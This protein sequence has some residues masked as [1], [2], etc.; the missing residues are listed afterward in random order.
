MRA[1]RVLVGGAL[2]V[3]V[4]LLAWRSGGPRLTGERS[5]GG[6]SATSPAGALAP[7]RRDPHRLARASIAGRITT[8]TADGGAPIGNAN[9]CAVADDSRLTGEES[10]DPICGRSAED[11]TY[12]LVDLVPASHRIYASAR[13]HRPAEYLDGDRPAN[14]DLGPGENRR[15]VD[16]VLATGGER[17]SGLV[18]DI[19]GG[20]VA[21]A[22]VY[23]WRV[24][25]RRA[26]GPRATTLSDAEG[27]FELWLPPG[28]AELIA[29]AEGYASG[30]R[31]TSAPGPS[32][33]ILL[34]PEATLIGRVVEI[35]SHRPVADAIVHARAENG[36]DSGSARS[37]A[38]GR[39]RLT[40]LSPGRYR[41]DAT[42]NTGFGASA[43]SVR[44]GLGQVSAE[45]RVELHPAVL[46]TGRV[47]R[48]DARPCARGQVELYD[49]LQD[50]WR[51]ADVEPDGEVRLQ[52]LLPGRYEVTVWCEDSVPADRYPEVDVAA[53]PIHGLRWR[54]GAGHVVRGVVVATDGAPLADIVV[55]AESVRG[56][57]GGDRRWP[58]A[59][60]DAAG[61]FRIPGVRPGRH[62]LQPWS[63]DHT[64]P[65]DPVE[66]TVD[67]SRD[68]DGVRIVMGRGETIEGTVVEAGGKPLGGVRVTA[69]VQG[70]T[71]EDPCTGDDGAFV[72]HGLVPGRYRVVAFDEWTP[73]RSPGRDDDEP[74]G[75]EVAVARGQRARVRLVV[76]R[77][78]GHI[79]GRVLDAAGKPVTD[80]LI[81]AERESEATGMSA[82][83]A[84]QAVRW[85]WW[86]QPALTDTNGRFT[87]DRLAPGRYT[88]HAARKGGG[89]VLAEHV[90]AGD[91]IT[92]KIVENGRIE[93][94]AVGPDGAAPQQFSITLADRATSFERREQYFRTAGRFRLDDLPAGRFELTIDSA[95]ASGTEQVTLGQGEVKPDVR[96]MLAGLGTVRGRVVALDDGAPVPG[97]SMLARQPGAM[98]EP[99]SDGDRQYVSDADGRFEL[100]RVPAG[101]V[102][103][104]GLPIDADTRSQFSILFG[105]PVTVRPGE[106]VVLPELRVARLRL[107]DN[108]SAGGDLGFRLEQR[109]VGADD[110]WDPTLKV[111]FVRPD[112]PAARAGLRVGDQIVAIDG[113]DVRGDD[114]YLYPMLVRVPEGTR[115]ALD[116]A[117][118]AT[119]SIIAGAPSDG[120]PGLPSGW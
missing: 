9:V 13:G 30:T 69:Y 12:A 65:S 104:M 24:D 16:V 44:L 114:A 17:V 93:G 94:V 33:V 71:L 99:R 5:S 100:D 60:T 98:P 82:G 102:F 48:D 18:K 120:S 23:G 10:R 64:G 7:P 88:V 35:G 115:I 8:T 28:S 97:M 29:E 40:R 57:P 74:Q 108:Y 27:R 59:K 110:P 14:V 107:A 117:R 6:A 118:G 113:H 75:V 61:R 38:E 46:V 25:N 111:A 45:V 56:D 34:T 51:G 109:E 90:R 47:D 66:V 83:G 37:D 42:T 20:P 4:A 116:V 73:L 89:E 112:G 67:E 50:V 43:D 84:R 15:G 21:G 103:L 62:H 32:A 95:S 119:I 86:R 54:V 58:S 79:R 106:L 53:A 80:A 76:E 87:I 68:T 105:W 31:V 63:S 1:R 96:I 52:G 81:R 91:S 11:G 78:D 72:L 70:W 49:P 2:A 36:D 3:I 19:A 92:L 85:I 26:G 22:R 55:T 39:F 41:A 77:R 101:K